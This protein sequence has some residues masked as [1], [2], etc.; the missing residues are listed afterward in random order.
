VGNVIELTD[1]QAAR[2]SSEADLV[3]ALY[4]HQIAV[5]TLERATGRPVARP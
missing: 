1:A 4:E 3:R 5:A 2:A